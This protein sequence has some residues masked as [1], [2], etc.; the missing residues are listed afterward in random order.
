[1]FQLTVA[2]TSVVVVLLQPRPKTIR[3]EQVVNCFFIQ[4][5]GHYECMSVFYMVVWLVFTESPGFFS[6]GLPV[7]GSVSCKTSSP[8]CLGS[9][10]SAEER[11]SKPGSFF[12]WRRCRHAPP[13]VDR[14]GS[15]SA[16]PSC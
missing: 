3:L 9:L 7:L 12:P 15:S 10:T 4:N 2:P 14:A 1:M 5:E 6:L 11:A 13:P 8:F 16:Q